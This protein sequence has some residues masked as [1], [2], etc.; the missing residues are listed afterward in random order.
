M[1][2]LG[3]GLY[4]LLMTRHKVD[5]VRMGILSAGAGLVL[6]QTLH[7]FLP[8]SL[9]ACDRQF[10]KGRL[11]AAAKAPSDTLTVSSLKKRPFDGFHVYWLTNAELEFWSTVGDPFA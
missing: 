4:Q 10:R 9:Q 2:L 7:D 3:A 1:Y 8:S 11:G 6:P 5:R